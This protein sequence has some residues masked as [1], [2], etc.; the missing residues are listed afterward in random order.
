[1]G[2]IIRPEAEI[3]L[4]QAYAWYQKQRP[5]LGIEFME[6]V[7][8]CIQLIEERPLSFSMS[9]IPSRRAIVRRFPYALYFIVGDEVVAVIAAF[10]MARHPRVLAQRLGSDA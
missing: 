6:E 4:S 5:G 8:R 1:M 9:A 10:H 7:E 2:L 3:D